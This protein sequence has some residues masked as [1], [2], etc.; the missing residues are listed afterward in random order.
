MQFFVIHNYQYVLTR[1]LKPSRYVGTTSFA[2]TPCMVTYLVRAFIA[3]A[4]ILLAHSTS[5]YFPNWKKRYCDDCIIK[6][7]MIILLEKGEKQALPGLKSICVRCSNCSSY[8]VFL[9]I[10]C[11]KNHLPVDMYNSLLK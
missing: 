1:T 6:Y 8:L 5:D 4:L 9:F 7:S 11:S 3:R 2:T 10:S